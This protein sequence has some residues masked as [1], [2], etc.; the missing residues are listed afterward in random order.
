M[1]TKR[2][3]GLVACGFI[4]G[5]LAT[6]VWAQTPTDVRAAIDRG[7]DARAL[8]HYTDAWTTHY[9]AWV[10]CAQQTDPGFPELGA[11]AHLEMARDLFAARSFESAATEFRGAG[12]QCQ[13]W[14]R[15]QYAALIGLAK[16]Y[17]ELGR[18]D[19]AA[20]TADA[21][22]SLVGQ[23]GVGPTEL[24]GARVAS[25][26]ARVRAAV[27]RAKSGDVAGAKAALAALTTTY[28]TY[29]GVT[30][31]ARFQFACCLLAEGRPFDAMT[32]FRAVVA[33]HSDSYLAARA[34]E[35][36]E[37][38]REQYGAQPSSFALIKEVRGGLLFI[39]ELN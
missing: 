2:T 25:G 19:D 29:E 23:S 4:G 6:T 22:Q 31:K 33:L 1:T 16:S 21:A 26:E 7:N 28:A 18:F 15:L 30:A 38:L 35:R 14:P 20:Q 11:W 37:E 9:D 24:I 27:M 32:A 34:L 39:S 36:L 12:G 5:L 3:L 13:P 10:Y 17:S 8:F